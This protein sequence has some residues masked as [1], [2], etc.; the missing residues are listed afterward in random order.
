[1]IEDMKVTQ[2][3]RVLG[4][5]I[6]ISIGLTDISEA[7]LYSDNTPFITIKHGVGVR[8]FSGKGDTDILIGMT[9]EQAKMICEGLK[10]QIK[11]LHGKKWRFRK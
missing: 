4:E 2:K 6:N 10:G 5:D 7:K 9:E 1:M 8:V 11:R 3:R